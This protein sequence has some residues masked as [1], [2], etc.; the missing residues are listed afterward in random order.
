MYFLLEKFLI[1]HSSIYNF[2]PN[3]LLFLGLGIGSYLLLTYLIDSKI[4]ELFAAIINELKK[5]I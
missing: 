2:L 5:I 3:F 1:Y 4:R